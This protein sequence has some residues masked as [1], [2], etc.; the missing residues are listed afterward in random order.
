MFDNINYDASIFKTTKIPVYSIIFIFGAKVNQRYLP[1][2]DLNQKK[3][4]RCMLGLGTFLNG[5]RKNR[6]AACKNGMQIESQKVGQKSFF[7]NLLRIVC[8]F[9]FHQWIFIQ[10]RKNYQTI[11]IMKGFRERRSIESLLIINLKQNLNSKSKSKSL[12]IVI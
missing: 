2:T 9:T 1:E 4:K 5:M 11:K 7:S 6:R 3:F 8:S 10:F 12:E